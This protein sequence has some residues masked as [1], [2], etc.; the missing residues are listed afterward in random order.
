VQLLENQTTQLQKQVECAKKEYTRQKQEETFDKCALSKVRKHAD[1][2][3][4]KYKRQEYIFERERTKTN[5]IQDKLRTETEL[6]TYFTNQIENAKKEETDTQEKLAVQQMEAQRLRQ[7]VDN[8]EQEYQTYVSKNYPVHALDIVQVSPQEPYYSQ[9][10]TNKLITMQSN[11]DD[12]ILRWQQANMDVGDT[13]Y[14]LDRIRKTISY[15]V[16]E[17]GKTQNRISFLEQTIPSLQIR[18]TQTKTV[19]TKINSEVSVLYEKLRRQYDST[20]KSF[21]ELNKEKAAMERF[22]QKM[23][24]F[25]CI[26]TTLQTLRQKMTRIDILHS[27]K[28]VQET[29][30]LLNVWT[31]FGGIQRDICTQE[32]ESLWM[33]KRYIEMEET[34][35]SLIESQKDAVSTTKESGTECLTHATLDVQS[36]KRKHTEEEEEERKE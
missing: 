28:F 15:F 34:K 3:R 30:S 14:R 20:K 16:S 4:Q 13:K 27:V 9:G 10:H 33:L 17:L 6:Q 25:N 11:V 19:L 32:Q 8:T 23:E 36:K 18:M 24:V 2:V 31:E 29:I 5:I 7:H 35:S 12:V 21:D 26:W 22:D 1:K